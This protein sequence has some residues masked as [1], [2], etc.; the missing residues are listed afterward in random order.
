L[1]GREAFFFDEGL[2]QGLRL[3]TAGTG[4]KVTAI[5]PGNVSTDLHELSGDA[6]AVERYSSTNGTPLLDP[7]D[8]AASIVHALRQP[9]HVA[10]NEI[11][12]EP[13]EEPV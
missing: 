1:E 6:E 12:V 7:Q 3:E 4:I 2:S 9:E 11:L 10:V 13:R 5:Q 8:V